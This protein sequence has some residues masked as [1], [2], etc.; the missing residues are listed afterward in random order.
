MSNEKDNSRAFE[1]LQRLWDAARSLSGVLVFALSGVAS[2][3]VAVTTARTAIE[4]RLD[5]LETLHQSDHQV[6]TT[7]LDELENS[8][9]HHHNLGIDGVPHPQGVIIALEKLGRE[10]DEKARD[11]WTKSDE[12]NWLIMEHL[13][14]KNRVDNRLE[15]LENKQL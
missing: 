1:N 5:K 3:A 13:P 2:I 12:I 7:R 10:A 11:R 6:L 4:H 8:I 9:K 15:K 14:W